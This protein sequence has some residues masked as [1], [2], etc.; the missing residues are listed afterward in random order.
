MHS[1]LPQDL[2]KH[3][4]TRGLFPNMAEDGLQQ[5]PVPPHPRPSRVG[6]LLVDGLE[7]ES[8]GER[9][10]RH[11]ARVLDAFHKAIKVKPQS[12]GFR[13]VFWVSGA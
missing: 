4:E 3:L 12:Q 10:V 5:S 6:G 13:T 11:R 7:D 9:T 2:C 1:F 8:L